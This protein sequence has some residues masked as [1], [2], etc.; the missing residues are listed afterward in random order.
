MAAKW[1]CYRNGC[2][3]FLPI[4]TRTA[5]DV[6][7]ALLHALAVSWQWGCLLLLTAPGCELLLVTIVS[8]CIPSLEPTWHVPTGPLREVG[9][10]HFFWEYRSNWRVCNWTQAF[11]DRIC[12]TWPFLMWLLFSDLGT[13]KELMFSLACVKTLRRKIQ[14]AE[15]Y[16]KHSPLYYLHDAMPLRGLGLTGKECS[17]GEH[18]GTSLSC[19]KCTHHPL[20]SLKEARGASSFCVI[21]QPWNLNEKFV[22]WPPCRHGSKGLE[23]NWHR[24]LVECTLFVKSCSECSGMLCMLCRCRPQRRIKKIVSGTWSLQR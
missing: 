22:R 4:C 8:S 20:L 15:N 6:Y 5:P 13:Q 16:F 7:E 3:E 21:F 17:Q 2:C 14:I 23:R 10:G 24:I 12:I 19:L 11:W 18:H 9:N 1:G